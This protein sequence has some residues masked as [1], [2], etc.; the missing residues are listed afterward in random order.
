MAAIKGAVRR[1][2]LVTTYGVGSVIALADESFM[3]AGI[4]KWGISTANLH[5]PRLERELMVGGFVVPPATD[6]GDI[7]V[8]RF[9]RWYSCPKCKRLDEHRRLT[10][11]ESNTCGDCSRP[12]VPSR[13]VMVC[14]RGHIDD[15]PY[16]RWVHE[17]RPSEGTTHT[18]TIESRGATASLRDI[19]IRCTCGRT[20]TMDKA[21]DKFALRDVTKCF[22]NRPWLGREQEDCD[23]QV[24]A[25]QRGASNVWFG[26][27]RSVISIPPWS[28]TAFQLLD[29]HWDIFRA[30]PPAAL[31]PAIEAV[32]LT[33]G[34]NFT[35]ADLVE[36]VQ[37]RK[38]RQ[39]GLVGP[40]SEEE[41]RRDEYRALTLG[42][43]DSAGAQFAAYES[44][45]SE[46]VSR[47]I[48]RVMLVTRLREVRALQGFSRIL[49]P[50]GTEGLAPLFTA[51]PGWR[52]AIEVR[53]EGLFL[54]LDA[55]C[56][57]EWE[58]RDNVL[59]RIQALDHRYAERATKMGPRARARDHASL[60][61]DPHARTCPHR[62]ARPRRRLSGGV[63]PRAAL[64]LRR[65]VRPPHLYRDHRLRREP[66]RPGSPRKPRAAGRGVALL[67]GEGFMVFGRPHLRRDRGAGGGRS[68]PCRVPRMHAPPGDQ[69][70]GD[71]RPPRPSAPHR[72]TRR[73]RA[74]LP[75]RPARLMARMLPPT[76]AHD[77]GS[78]AERTVFRK[79]KEE[80]PDT[81]VALHS[82]GLINHASKPWAEIDFVVI[83]VDGVL[84]LEVKGGSVVH[85]EGDWYQNERRM[86]ESP[87]A[88][89]GG[90][91]SALYDY[92]ATHVQPVRHSFV[93]HGVLF[94]EATFSL[95][96]PA[97]DRQMIFDDRDLPRPMSDYIER[98][99]R[100]WQ[101]NLQRK[102]GRQPQGLDRAARSLVVH[103]LAPDFELVPSLRAR[104]HDVEDELIRLT[105]Q[106]KELLDGLIETPRV[107]VRGGAGTGKT[108]IACAEAARL[109]ETGKD[110]LLVCYSAR[111]AAHLRPLLSM[112]GVRVAHLHGLM[113]ELIEEAGMRD[114]LPAVH[115]RD[116]FDIHYPELAIEALEQLGR[117]GSVD[118]LVVDE[119]QD[120]LKPLHVLFLDALLEGELA[121]GTWRLFHDPNQDIFLGGPPA[122]LDRLETVA[123]C[124]R[125]TRN[126][127]NTREVAMATSILSGVAVSETLDVDGPDVSE[128]WY[129]DTRTQHKLL[130]G[131]LRTWVEQG[132]SPADIT[133]LTPGRL[134]RSPLAEIQPSK[135]PRPIVD[136]SHAGS[137]DPN[138]IRFSTVASFKGLESEAVLLT[139]VSDLTETTT[140]SLL[141]VAASRA[142]V[143]L[144]LVL[145]EQSRA[146]YIERARDV[147]ERLVE[148]RASGAVD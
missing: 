67:H 19:E 7:P 58:R 129:A 102:F 70:R 93:G 56:V 115:A 90:G 137:D 38:R 139:G 119:A 30:L 25:L 5:E 126:C 54:V 111:L 141:Y 34:T 45:R 107:V 101:T 61:P 29:K 40:T 10:T 36:A 72:I 133:I 117:F 4:D 138:K 144:S 108:L 44:T 51:D 110:T 26:S 11:F 18:L 83:T 33:A 123:T 85:R 15:F 69:L 74:G 136:V 75:H 12:L 92:L 121:G 59:R 125:L 20:R 78:R 13:F 113:S 68:Q 148:A 120:I 134:E 35:T 73:R 50:G 104:L 21:F 23:Q 82:V 47:S 87:F 2:Q 81:W 86:K 1:S 65:H 118:A 116:L 142:R 42:Q 43:D 24:R 32:G 79:L 145:D 31:G 88:Q 64:R 55:S 57:E 6:D 14:P 94:P 143:L 99:T 127:R 146:A 106:Q 100:Y 122:E 76:I 71:E 97:V 105:E 131:Q 63:A 147:V 49:P 16:I 9:P 60:R 22:G 132:V 95:D 66:R 77:H 27:H 52:P 53:G 37:E 128:H 8:V 48:S 114:R 41:V 140:L 135:L 130:L 84:C 98:L 39:E 3:V 96:L 80:T 28:D 112:A 103:E 109:S 89:A 91:A 17:G 124:Y 46:S 62:P